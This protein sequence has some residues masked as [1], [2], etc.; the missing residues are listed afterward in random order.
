MAFYIAMKT[1]AEADQKAKELKRIGKWN[2]TVKKM[3][4][5]KGYSGVVWVVYRY[6]K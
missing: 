4:N 3:K 1:K 5:T 2:T 6:S